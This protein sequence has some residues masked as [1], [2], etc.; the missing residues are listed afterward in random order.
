M[1]AEFLVYGKLVVARGNRPNL[2]DSRGVQVTGRPADYSKV[3]CNICVVSWRR[4][5]AFF[6]V[7]L[8]EDV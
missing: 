2:A 8:R 4:L 3:R 5:R 7:L 1:V 6:V